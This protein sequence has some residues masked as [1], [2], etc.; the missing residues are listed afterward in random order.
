MQITSQKVLLLFTH[1]NIWLGN[2]WSYRTTLYLGRCT[3]C[4]RNAS[5]FI[6]QLLSRVWLFETPW[7][8]ACQA[9]LSIT[10][11]WCLLKLI[12]IVS[13][14]QSN[15]CIL[16]HPFFFLPSIFPSIRIF[17]MSQLFASG[18]QS[19]G[20][21]ASASVLPMNIQGWFPLDWMVWSPCS[22]R[23]SQ[24]SSPAPQLESIQPS[25]WSNSYILSGLP[26]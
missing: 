26:W 11:S 21:S 20:V 25:L 12:A 6:V 18:G 5:H 10:I 15:H 23:D 3:V 4:P 22:P 16:C 2:P 8:A 17:S 7:A 13:M 1:R 9:S 14:M 19:I 24:E